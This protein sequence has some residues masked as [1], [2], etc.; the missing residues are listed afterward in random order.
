MDDGFLLSEWSTPKN[1][2]IVLVT[3]IDGPVTLLAG[4]TSTEGDDVFGVLLSV[5]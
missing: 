5:V 3:E 1:F 2:R 4:E